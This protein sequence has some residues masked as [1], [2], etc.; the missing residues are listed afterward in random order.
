MLSVFTLSEQMVAGRCISILLSAALLCCPARMAAHLR[1]LMSPGP[2][3]RRRG[4]DVREQK[5]F[6][7]ILA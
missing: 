4:A 3:L 5:V 2:R 7:R 6:C 1:L